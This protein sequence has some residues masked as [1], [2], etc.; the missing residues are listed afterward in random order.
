MIASSDGLF[1]LEGLC[2]RSADDVCRVAPCT[3]TWDP[4]N[5]A[6]GLYRRWPV[7]LN[8]MPRVRSMACHTDWRVIHGCLL[9]RF[10]LGKSSLSSR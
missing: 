8:M 3:C 5:L 1:D 4:L 7:S 9:P 10:R 2:R 6:A